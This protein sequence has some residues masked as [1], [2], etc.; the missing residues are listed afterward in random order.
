MATLIN[1]T[2]YTAICFQIN[3]IFYSC[4]IN[5]SVAFRTTPAS[6]FHEDE[7]KS[8]T[9]NNYTLATLL[10]YLTFFNSITLKLGL[11]NDH[12]TAL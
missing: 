2:K 8:T 12:L 10:V 3:V 5:F 11:I 1:I 9:L 7:N 6:L 4:T